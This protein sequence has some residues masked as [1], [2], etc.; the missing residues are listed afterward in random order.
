ML[1]TPQYE[2]SKLSNIVMQS[3]LCLHVNSCCFF[4]LYITA[5]KARHP[6]TSI[7]DTKK[8][9]YTHDLCMNLENCAFR[10]LIQE[11]L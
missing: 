6:T 11:F 3:K 8:G 1:P 2:R 7:R 10:G 9:D 4:L 5:H